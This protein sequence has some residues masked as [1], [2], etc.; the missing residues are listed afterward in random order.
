MESFGGYPSSPLI[1]DF[2]GEINHALFTSYHVFLS[3]F[4]YHDQLNHMSLDVGGPWDEH[5][6]WMI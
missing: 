4:H 1:T 6:L 2:Q 3:R 5:A